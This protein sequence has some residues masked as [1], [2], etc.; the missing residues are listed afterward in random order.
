M[1]NKREWSYTRT[2]A[3]CPLRAAHVEREQRR[4]PKLRKSWPTP[5]KTAAKGEGAGGTRN[6]DSSVT[7]TDG[8]GTR[9]FNSENHYDESGL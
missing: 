7:G 6:L 4:Y 3:D 5:M 8:A 9:A 2:E 1:S